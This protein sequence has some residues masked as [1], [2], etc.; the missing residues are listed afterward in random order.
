MSKAVFSFTRLLGGYFRLVTHSLLHRRLRASLTIVGIV[1]GISIVLTLVFLG[2]GLQSSITGQL[3]QFGTDLIFI[4]PS[5]ASNPLAGATSGGKFSED[6]VRAVEATKGATSVM[7][8]IRN[9]LISADFRGEKKTVGV[10]ARP[11]DLIESFLVQSLGIKL[12]EGR[13]ML[14]EDSREV[15]LGS[16]VAANGFRE[17]VRIGDTIDFRGHRITVVGILQKFGDQTR[18]N[19]IIMTVGLFQLLTGQRGGYDGMLV[20][21]EQGQ[22]IEAV[23]RNLED[24]LSGQT[25]LADYTVLTPSKSQQVVGTVVGTVQSALFLIASVAVLVAGI[26]VMN[27][28]YTSVLERT[29]EIGVMKSIGAK[30]WHIKMVFVLESMLLGGCGGLIGTLGGAALAEL[31]AA[32]ARAKG[33]TFFQAAID[34]PTIA[35][36]LA[37]TLVIGVLAGIL[38]AR[39]A[40]RKRPVEA[41]RYR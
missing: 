29:R 24:T 36:V 6:D 25:D 1:I 14:N 3:Q 13:W 17:P 35:Y 18:D 7:P 4:L 12:A 41:L 26:G 40:A 39:E 5:D 21:V 30:G 34:L 9:Y 32:L 28:M 19:L 16:N 37:F 31:V 2:N 22:D 11:R 10:E 33:F 27:T 23:G 38:P 8:I 20:K 15:V